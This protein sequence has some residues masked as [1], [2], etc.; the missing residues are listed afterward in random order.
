MTHRRT[1]MLLAL[2]PL[3]AAAALVG[4]FFWIVPQSL[5]PDFV[6][7]QPLETG[8]LSGAQSQT[9]TMAKELNSY[10]ISLTTLIFGGFGWYVTQHK[11]SMRPDFVRAT[12]FSAVGFTS[13]AAWYA[14][15]AYAQLVS[16]LAQDTL[17][18]V[19]GQ[20]RI[21]YYLELEAASCG[22][23]ALLIL[24]VFAAAVTRKT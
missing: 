2:A 18:L 15:Q 3:G 21:L 12:F 23:G 5:A 13:L 9:V 14:F 24:L 16:E 20:S 11:P 22:C 10:L 17:A 6:N 4:A 1:K 19:P 7:Y 8:T